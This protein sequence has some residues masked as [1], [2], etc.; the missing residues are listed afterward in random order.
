MIKDLFK[1]ITRYFPSKLIEGLIGFITILIITR[2]FSPNDYGNYSLTLATIN[3]LVIFIGWISMAIIRFY[4]EYEKYKKL[5]YFN[6]N[7]IKLSFIIIAAISI[8]FLLSIILIKN[9]LS[10]QLYSFMLI[11]NFLFVLIAFFEI[12]QAFL[13][14]KREIIW[15]SIFLLFKVVFGFILGMMLII[16]FNFGIDGLFWGTIISLLLILPVLWKKSVE[17]IRFNNLKISKSFVWEISN[18]SLPLVVSNLAAWLL[19]LSDR[20]ILKLYKGSHEVGIYSASYNISE[21]S[22]LL[23]ASLILLASGPISIN[24][25]EKKGLDESKIF[26]NKTTRLFLII[27]IPLV[28]ILS[29]LSKPIIMLMTGNEYLD[30]YK[31]VPLVVSGAF[32]LGLQQRFQLAFLFYKKTKILLFATVTSG[33]LNL[34]LNLFLIPKYGYMG[35]AITTFV[36]YLILFLLVCF[37]SRRFFVW[38]FPYKSMIK[39]IFSSSVMGADIYFLN[40]TFDFT[41]SVRL[42]LSILSGILIYFLFL[43]ILNE[44]TKKEKL[45]IFKFFNLKHYFI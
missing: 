40:R 22:I 6:I 44:L 34:I 31:I 45:Y 26:V 43:I 3:I 2:L 11:G 9:R 13:R 20:Y 7:I 42:A 35:A 8:L 12:L 27:C 30:G 21:N 32:F 14:S 24:I 38:N 16:L 4:P 33:L 15:Y 23:L 5:V 1:D 29:I 17:R 28:V 37:F 36:S 39:V 19:R 18:Y 25:W 41:I 10:S